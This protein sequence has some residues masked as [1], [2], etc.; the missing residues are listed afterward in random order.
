MYTH[1]QK[2]EFG[3]K[4]APTLLSLILLIFVSLTVKVSIFLVISEGDPLCKFLI[5]CTLK[6]ILFFL[7]YG[8]TLHPNNMLNYFISVKPHLQNNHPGNSKKNKTPC[9][10]FSIFIGEFQALTGQQLLLFVIY[11]IVLVCSFLL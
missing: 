8:N 10:L 4:L 6:V 5:L 9:L 2:S 3:I 1:Q 11:Q 7:F